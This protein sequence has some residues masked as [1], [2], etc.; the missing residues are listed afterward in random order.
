MTIYKYH[1]SGGHD[2]GEVQ[3]VEMP[4]GARILHAGFQGNATESLNPTATRE[5]VG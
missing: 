2:F 3:T 4:Y 5:R 1:L